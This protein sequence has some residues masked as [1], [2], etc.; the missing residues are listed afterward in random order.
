MFWKTFGPTHMRSINH[1]YN[2]CHIK[3]LLYDRGP[4]SASAVIK[5]AWSQDNHPGS[6]SHHHQSIWGGPYMPAGACLNASWRVAAAPFRGP[7]LHL[8]V[9]CQG[10]IWRTL[11]DIYEVGVSDLLVWFKKK[12][13]TVYC[14]SSATWFRVG[15]IPQNHTLENGELRPSSSWCVFGAAAHVGQTPGTRVSETQ[16]DQLLVIRQS[17]I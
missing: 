13:K 12:T 5:L 17:L 15:I 10:Q 16:A 7:H 8:L 2:A 4:Q 14:A 9:R 1:L 6:S 11:G 3:K